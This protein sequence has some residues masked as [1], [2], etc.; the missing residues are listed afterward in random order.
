MWDYINRKRINETVSGPLIVIQMFASYF[1]SGY[2]EPVFERCFEPF[3]TVEVDAVIAE[4][5][6]W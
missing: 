1:N 2:N 3:M 4:I 5:I 6:A